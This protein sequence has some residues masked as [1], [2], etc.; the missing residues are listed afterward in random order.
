[1]GARDSLHGIKYFDATGNIVIAKIIK[2]MKTLRRFLQAHTLCVHG[3]SWPTPLLF[4]AFNS[5]DRGK[6]YVSGFDVALAL[7]YTNGPTVEFSY[8]QVA[9]AKNNINTASTTGKRDAF[10]PFV[11]NGT[12][13]VSYT[14]AA[15]GV[16]IDKGWDN[17]NNR[18]FFT[19]VGCSVT[20]TLV[21]YDS[22]LRGLQ[23]QVPGLSVSLP[24]QQC[25]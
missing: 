5:K 22:A 4:F 20:I 9:T 10:I 14:D 11:P 12:D 15:N 16:Y 6:F 3:I 23:K 19:V 21:P 2:Q 18:Y 1:M 24:Q 17:Q 8:R 25:E 7:H 13:D